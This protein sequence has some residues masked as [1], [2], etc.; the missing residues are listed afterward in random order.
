MVLEGEDGDEERLSRAKRAKTTRET[1]HN[2]IGVGRVSGRS[3][4][5]P[6]ETMSAMKKGTNV[7]TTWEKK[8]KEKAVAKELR[9]RKQE[10]KELRQAAM[11]EAREKREAAKKRKEENRVKS[12]ITQIVS[13]KTARKMAKNKKLRKKLVTVDG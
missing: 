10:A 7:S 8:M 3:W 9:E 5:V 1:K 6:G 2:T 13:S 4:K 12:A 11:K